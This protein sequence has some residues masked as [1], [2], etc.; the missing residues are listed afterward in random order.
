MKYD[1]TI[2]LVEGKGGF[3]LYDTTRG[4]NLSM[5]AKTKDAAW[6]DAVK[7]YQKRLLKIEEEL[8]EITGKV[9]NFVSSVTPEE[10]TEEHY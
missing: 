7:Y 1:K 3:W 4:M 2:S 8:K 6:F 9:D 5:R 10:Q